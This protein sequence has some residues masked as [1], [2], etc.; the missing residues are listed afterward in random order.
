MTL[1]RVFSV[2][3]VTP[4][5]AITKDSSIIFNLKKKFYIKVDDFFLVILHYFIIDEI[6]DKRYDFWIA[7]WKYFLINIFSIF[8][9]MNFDVFFNLNSLLLYPSAKDFL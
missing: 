8:R 5:L 1:N 9:V 7:V 4:G 2:D 6:K 3:T